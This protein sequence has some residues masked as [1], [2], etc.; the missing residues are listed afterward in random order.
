[1]QAFTKAERLSSKIK[2]TQLFESGK[3]FHSAPFKVIWQETISEHRVSAQIVISVPKRL[4]KRA[5][6]RNRLKRLFREVYRKNKNILYDHLN[7]KKILL[8]FIFTGKSM[9]DYKEMEEKIIIVLQRLNKSIN[10]SEN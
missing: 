8:L 1:M 9:I 10:Q 7:D 5:V 3:S 6:D 2:I 4:F